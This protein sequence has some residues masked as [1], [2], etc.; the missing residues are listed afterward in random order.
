MGSLGGGL[1]LWK[2]RRGGEVAGTR[3]GKIFGK[4]EPTSG[5][6]MQVA[7]LR[8]SVFISWSRRPWVI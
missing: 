4:C 8:D 2:G 6:E 1:W 5:G 7:V 3:D